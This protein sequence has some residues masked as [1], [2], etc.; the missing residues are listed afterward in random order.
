MNAKNPD[1]EKGGITREYRGAKEG[2][3]YMTHA[4]LRKG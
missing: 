1:K 3:G 2:L 4:N